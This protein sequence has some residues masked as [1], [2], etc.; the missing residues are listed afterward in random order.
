MILVKKESNVLTERSWEIQEG[1]DVEENK[2]NSNLLNGK[3]I[4]W[5]A[6]RVLEYGMKGQP[7]HPKFAKYIES[8]C[9]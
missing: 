3:V 1:E 9:C 6:S 5:W 4:I 7:L 2:E 8:A